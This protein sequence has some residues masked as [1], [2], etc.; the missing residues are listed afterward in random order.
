METFLSQ[1]V[2]QLSHDFSTKVPVQKSKFCQS[3]EPNQ[4]LQVFPSSHR[5][6]NSVAKIKNN[7]LYKRE[8]IHFSE[9][10]RA[11]WEVFYHKS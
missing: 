1:S 11:N 10:F 3:F 9:V 7:V 8:K 2:R 5:M 6:V 4:D